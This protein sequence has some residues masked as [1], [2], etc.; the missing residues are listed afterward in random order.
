MQYQTLANAAGLE[1]LQVV[2]PVQ[3][4]VSPV[5]QGATTMA[6]TTAATQAAAQPSQTQS[7][8]VS[9]TP[10]QLAQPTASQE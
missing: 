7:P 2:Q 6:T 8:R 5:S 10:T 4:S 1:A 3:Q 9:S